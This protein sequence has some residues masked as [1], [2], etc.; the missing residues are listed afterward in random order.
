MRGTLIDGP[1][2][3]D[4][5]DLIIARSST[6]FPTD[7]P[8]E[9]AQCNLSRELTDAKDGKTRGDERWPQTVRVKSSRR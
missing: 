4:P 7:R 3:Q 2:I 5:L 6:R 8:T 1:T 9:L